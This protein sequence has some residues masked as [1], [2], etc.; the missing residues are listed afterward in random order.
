MKLVLTLFVALLPLAAADPGSA[1][2]KPAAST[3][4]VPKEVQI[5]AEAVETTPGTWTYTDADGKKW[6]YRKT[7]FGVARME[8]KAANATLLPSSAD[9]KEPEVKATESG[10]TVHFERPG[11]FGVYKWDR[12]KAELSD[13]ERGWLEKAQ[14]RSS[15]SEPRKQN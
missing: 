4:A 7:P 9:R 13:T 12:K 3:K 6:L 8:E 11:P 1:K 10:D 2:K 5:P 14:S 15:S